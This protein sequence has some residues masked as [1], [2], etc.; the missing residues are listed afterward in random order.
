MGEGIENASA[1]QGS[2]PAA[3]QGKPQ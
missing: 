3:V 1:E 2:H